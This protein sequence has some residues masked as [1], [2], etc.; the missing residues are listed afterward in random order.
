LVQALSLIKRGVDADLA[1]ALD[2]AE[3]LAWCVAMGELE[4]RTFDWEEMR[5]QD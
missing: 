3:R 5:W 1:F 4:G 2:D